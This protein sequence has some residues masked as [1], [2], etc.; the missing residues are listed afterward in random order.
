MK[1]KI[2]KRELIIGICTLIVGLSLGLLFFKSS[3]PV[4]ETTHEHSAYEESETTIW[5]CSM[6]PQIRMDKPGKCPICAMDLIP[7]V[8]ESEESAS[9]GE[10]QMTEAAMRIA[11]VQTVIVTKQKPEKELHLFG[12]LKPDERNIAELTARFGGR[13]EKLMVN[14]TGQNVVKGQ[15]LASIYSPELVTAQKELMEAMEYKE[16]NPEFY[17]AARNK[18]KLWD[19]TEEQIN[20]IESKGELQY[21]FEI[22]SPISGTIT[23]R[24]VALGDY[25]KVGSRLFEVIDLTNI[26]A[27]F[28]AYESD[29]PWI[30]IGDKVKFTIKAFPGKTYKGNVTYIDPFINSKT[31]IAN[32]RV[33]V[34]NPNLVLKPEMFANGIVTSNLSNSPADL[35][36]PKSSILWTGKRAVVYVKVPNREAPTF[37]YREIVLGPDVGEFYIVKEGLEEGEEIAMNGVFKIDAAAQLA[38]KPSM[39]NPEGGKISTGHDHGGMDMGEQKP[40]ASMKPDDHSLHTMIDESS[41]EIISQ[42]FKT[43]LTKV[44]DQYINLKNALV[45][46]DAQKAAKFV[47]EILYSLEKVDMGL[48]KGDAHMVWMN[49]LEKLKTEGEKIAESHNIDFQRKIF[50]YLSETFI[51]SV[52]RFGVDSE[53]IYVQFCPMADNEIGA[54]W[55][56]LEEQ[57]SNPYY[58]DMMLRCGEVKDIINQ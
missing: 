28:E 48:L 36:I 37:I 27:M 10:I 23:M 18:L 4:E 51:A 54:L 41:D 58:G 11:D 13:I 43:Q 16:S 35:Q 49:Q 30:N 15:K 1:I 2:S 29:L 5:T 14:F 38:G 31:R 8:T 53:T 34:S 50:K 3:E 47:R 9:P 33:E 57:I 46:A 6:H 42:Q 20:E 32:I 40:A 21:Y 19:L 44:F 26:W 24:H 12:K 39:M 17:K 25:I 22:L 52:K 7:L 56:S 55:M 45:K